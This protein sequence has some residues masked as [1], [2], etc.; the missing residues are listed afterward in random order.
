M[1]SPWESAEETMYH[2]SI[3]YEVMVVDM[4]SSPLSSYKI[5][6]RVYIYI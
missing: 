5:V 4:N 2:S 6:V 3:L 1:V